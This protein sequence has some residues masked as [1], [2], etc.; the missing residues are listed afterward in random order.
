MVG[1]GL[2]ED[3]SSRLFSLIRLTTPAQPRFVQLADSIVSA[4]NSQGIS[5]QTW[6]G[7]SL[8]NAWIKVSLGPSATGCSMHKTK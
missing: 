3:T 5:T 7:I 2:S 1:D 4:A 6:D 8:A